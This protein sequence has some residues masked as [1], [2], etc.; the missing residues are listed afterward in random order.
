VPFPPTT[1]R[2]SNGLADKS[3]GLLATSVEMAS[4]GFVEVLSKGLL[5]T[6]VEMVSKGFVE[7]LSKGLPDHIREV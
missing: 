7:M 1:E 2:S 4:K 3:K 5:A 6:S